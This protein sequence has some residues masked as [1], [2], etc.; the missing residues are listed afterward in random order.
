MRELEQYA[1]KCSLTTFVEESA[2]YEPGPEFLEPWV[3]AT[4]NTP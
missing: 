2:A 4:E 1:V 3:D